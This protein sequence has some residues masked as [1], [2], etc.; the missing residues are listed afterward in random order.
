MYLL[1]KSTSGPI[2]HSFEDIA[3]VHWM[4]VQRTLRESDAANVT[5][6]YFQRYLHI[7]YYAYDPDFSMCVCAIRVTGGTVQWMV[8]CQKEEKNQE[9]ATLVDQ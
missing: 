9:L 2:E 1:Q 5:G 7:A 3:A 6:L 4:L 8:W